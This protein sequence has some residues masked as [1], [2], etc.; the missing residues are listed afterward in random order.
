VKKNGETIFVVPVIPTSDG[1]SMVYGR[2]E[3]LYVLN[4]SWILE[5]VRDEIRKADDGSEIPI[6]VGELYLDGELLNE[7]YDYDAAFEFQILAGK[8]FFFFERDG[9]FGIS[10]DWHEYELPVESIIHYTCC[11][12]AANNPLHFENLVAFVTSQDQ[13][14]I[15]YE[16]VNIQG[17]ASLLDETIAVEK[18]D[19]RMELQQVSQSGEKL[20]LTVKYSLLDW[21]GWGISNIKLLIDGKSYQAPKHELIEQRY[22]KQED[23]VCLLNALT[24][25]TCSEGTSDD[26][27]RIERLTFSGLPEGLKDKMIELQIWQYKV[28]PPEGERYC[29]VMRVEYIQNILEHK[30]PGI[31]INCIVA[32]GMNGLELT[33]GT[34]YE[35]DPQ[36]KAD[37]LAMVEEIMSGSVVGPWSFVIAE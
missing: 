28:D 17:G 27:Y 10:Y 3:G 26:L 11:S 25:E 23:Q 31:K 18:N 4:E 8:P 7:K 16:L 36:A 1:L 9:K 13:K 37:L 5:V 20:T 35:D 29:D 6:L 12:G 30:Y 2:I 15:Y 34:P 19:V 22:Q 24:G 32:P 33:E 14:L 21:R